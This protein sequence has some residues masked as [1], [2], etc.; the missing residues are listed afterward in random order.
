MC[1]SLCVRTASGV[2]LFA[3]NSDR[4]PTEAQVLEA[5]P[6]RPSGGDI[7]TQ[8]LDIPDTGALQLVGSRPVWLWGFEHGVNER[9]VAIGNEAVYS[10]VP[11]STSPDGLIGMDLVR[12]GLERGRSAREAVD[13]MTTLLE[14]HGQSGDCYEDGGAYHSSFLVADRTEAWILETA[15]TTWV[16]QRSVRSAAISNRLTIRTGWELSSEDVPAGADFD[17]WR[18]PGTDTGFADVRLGASVACLASGPSRPADLVAHLRDHGGSSGMPAA[19]AFT[20]CMHIRDVSATTAAMVCE[21][22]EEIRIWAALG[23]PCVSVFVPFVFPDVPAIL[24]DPA[25]WARFAALR[26]RVE[27]DP[28]ALDGVRSALEPIERNLWTGSDTGTDGLIA[29]IEALA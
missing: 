3:K 16:A 5:F 7:R 20:V 15:G 1:D 22:G 27:R 14:R 12:L 18:D 17:A 29:V 26:D 23:S 24:S 9:G 2:M 8:Y 21:L 28:A 19:D 4:P 25:V 10:T 11:P 6:A 13:V